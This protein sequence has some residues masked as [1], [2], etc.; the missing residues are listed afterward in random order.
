MTPGTATLRRK[1]VSFGHDVKDKDAV[2]TREGRRAGRSRPSR[3]ASLTRAL[4]IAKEEKSNR[5]AQRGSVELP[6]SLNLDTKAITLELQPSAFWRKESDYLIKPDLL[7]ELARDDPDGGMTMDLNKP[8]SQSGRY[9]KS[10]FHKY[11]EEAQIQMKRLLQYKEGAKD[12]ARKKDAEVLELKQQ[13]KEA[14]RKIAATEDQ[15]SRS[16]RRK[17]RTEGFE[18]DDDFDVPRLVKELAKKTALCEQYKKQIDTSRYASE[19]SAGRDKKNLLSQ[20]LLT[21]TA[22]KDGSTHVELLREE[23]LHLQSTLKKAE[24]ETMKLQD[25]NKQLKEELS[26][27]ELKLE[28]Q[29]EKL[30]RRRESFDDMRRKKDDALDQLQKTYDH[31]KENAKSQRRDAEQLLKRRHDQAVELKKELATARQLETKVKQLQDKLQ[32]ATIEHSEAVANYEIQIA[33]LKR[34]VVLGADTGIDLRASIFKDPY[35]SSSL[36]KHVESP[37]RHRES[38]IPVASNSISRPSKATTRHTWSETPTSSPPKKSTLPLSEIINRANPTTIPS[39]QS[40]PVQ[41]TPAVH[42]FSD[43]SLPDPDFDLPSD[44]PS[45]E[46]ALPEHRHRISTRPAF[47][48]ISSSPPKPSKIPV[49]DSKD[50]F[51]NRERQTSSGSGRSNIDSSRIRREVAPERAAAAKAR[52]EQKMAEKRK[53][54][55]AA[56]PGKE[57]VAL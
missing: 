1:S 41:F 46:I 49:Q 8:H 38:H 27:S 16:S 23:I 7:E 34:D 29:T 14:E 5:S 20:D 33:E 35:L 17:I 44:E 54:Q 24:K 31:L 3:S 10:E 28:R 21:M 53:A 9:W 37:A 43:L 2:A 18:S 42:R 22:G 6:Q 51:W 11:H 57:N 19:S 52:L 45:I 50:R 48:S 4:E 12:F 15:K 13:L 56:A 36:A 39:V 32:N 40:G 25:E 26:H 47:V 30:E 55:A